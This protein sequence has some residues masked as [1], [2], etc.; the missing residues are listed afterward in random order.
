MA[1]AKEGKGEGGRGEGE[2]RVRKGEGNGRGDGAEG[3]EKVAVKL[4]PLPLIIF[5]L[6]CAGLLQQA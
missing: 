2:L 1:A 6:A 5:C 4:I 3:G